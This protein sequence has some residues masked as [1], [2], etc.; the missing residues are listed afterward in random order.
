MPQIISNTIQFH[1]AAYS[2]IDQQYKFLIIQRASNLLIYPNVWQVITGTLEPSETA[3][4][5]VLREVQE[6]IGFEISNSKLFSV[7][8]ITKFF[9]PK[10]DY[11]SLAPVFAAIIDIDTE[12]ILSSEHQ[13][14]QWVSA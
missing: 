7:P 12:I 14:Y 3:L 9:V 11:I 8:Y 10:K 6:E 2:P 1:I 5:C 4:Q 13:A